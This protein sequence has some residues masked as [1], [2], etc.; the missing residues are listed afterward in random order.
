M[1]VD[2]IDPVRMSDKCT[3]TPRVLYIVCFY[4]YSKLAMKG[5]MHSLL[6]WLSTC[7]KAALLALPA[8]AAPL[9]LHA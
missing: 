9:L 1:R 7:L 6:L 8:A 5:E 2:F 3:S 4:L